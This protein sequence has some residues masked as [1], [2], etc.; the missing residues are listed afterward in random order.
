MKFTVF[1]YLFFIF[2]LQSLAGELVEVEGE[3]KNNFQES[4]F[5]KL[6]SE[7]NG[8]KI[9]FPFKELTKSLKIGSEESGNI[10]LIPDGRSLVKKYADYKNPRI[11]FEPFADAPGFA[12]QGKDKKKNEVLQKLN[13]KEG[14]LF[15]GFAPNHKA[16]EVVSYNSKTGKTDFFIVENYEEGK[17]PKIVNSRGQC[18]SC[19]QNEGPIFSRFPWTESSGQTGH[20]ALK[21]NEFKENENQMMDLIRK[22]NP[23]RTHIEGIDLNDKK[24]FDLNRIA[25]FDLSARKSNESLLRAKICEIFCKTG[26]VKC[27]EKLIL[28]TLEVKDKKLSDVDFEYEIESINSKLEK[29]E[30]IS[31]VIPNRDP[32]LN[33]G[34]DVIATPAMIEAEFSHLKHSLAPLKSYNLTYVESGATNIGI[35]EIDNPRSEFSFFDP[36]KKRPMN[37]DLIKIKN[38]LEGFKEN[39][40]KIEFLADKCLM[41]NAIIKPNLESLSLSKAKEILKRPKVSKVIS[42]LRNVDLNVLDEVLK[43]EISISE[44]VASVSG[45]C[46]SVVSKSIIPVYQFMDIQKVNEKLSAETIDKPNQLIKRYCTECHGKN[47]FILLP[48]ESLSEMANYKPNFSDKGVLERIEKK[49]MPPP[50]AAFQPTDQEREEILKVLKELKK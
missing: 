4:A 13:I 20:T 28:K 22:A 32:V 38:Q 7:L 23:D 24:S 18:I 3:S 34:F 25:N 42:N 1:L 40:E 6:M 47:G 16:L 15:I 50:F 14:D 45:E 26:D 36:A 12:A 5:I 46:D 8:G 31:S 39:N 44:N 33:V 17:T 11:I 41:A 10:I 21:G 19:H 48:L 37:S 30:F 49:I 2:S 35:H 9:P 43:S 29:L 27:L